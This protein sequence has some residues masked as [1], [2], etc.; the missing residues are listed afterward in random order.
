MWNDFI[1]DLIVYTFQPDE[2]LASLAPVQPMVNC[3][4]DYPAREWVGPPVIDTELLSFDEDSLLKSDVE[5]VLFTLIRQHPSL[6]L[7]QSDS[8]QAQTIPC[9]G[10]MVSCNTYVW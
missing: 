6:N 4:M 1:K 9:M 7:F 10:S 8:Y 3:V 5:N 2:V